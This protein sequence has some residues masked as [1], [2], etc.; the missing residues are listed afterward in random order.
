MK[1]SL[2]GG[3]S[4]VVQI[5]TRIWHTSGRNPGQI[6]SES[7]MVL[8]VHRSLH[9]GIQRYRPLYGLPWA[10]A[11]GGVEYRKMQASMN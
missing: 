4:C 5:R 9:F 3:T 1:A 7:G 2:S 10:T 6:R 8:I 11:P